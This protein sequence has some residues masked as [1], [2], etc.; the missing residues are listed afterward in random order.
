MPS[1]PQ[2]GDSTLEHCAGKRAQ[3]PAAAPQDSFSQ[4]VPEGQSAITVQRTGGACASAAGSF[5]RTM[6]SSEH[7]ESTTT[8]PSATSKVRLKAHLPPQKH[9]DRTA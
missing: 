3:V 4:N 9:R 8:T 6:G 7:A 2:T 1:H 5:A